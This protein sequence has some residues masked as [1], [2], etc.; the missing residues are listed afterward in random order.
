MTICLCRLIL[1]YAVPYAPSWLRCLSLLRAG[2]RVC[3]EVRRSRLHLHAA[4]LPSMV[5]CYPT[6]ESENCE[7]LIAV[8]WPS[9]VDPST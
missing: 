5:A 8:K 7:E 4:W 9:L 6:R 1:S 2:A 3:C